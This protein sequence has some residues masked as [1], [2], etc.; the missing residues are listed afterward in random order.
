MK[1][2]IYCLVEGASGQRNQS[3]PE[4]LVSQESVDVTGKITGCYAA[5]R[6]S[7]DI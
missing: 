5:G 4:R 6:T 7:K 1:L 3:H 2:F